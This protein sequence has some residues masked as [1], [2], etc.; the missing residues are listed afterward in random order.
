MKIE[1]VVEYN[2][3]GFLVHAGNLQGAYVRGRTLEEALEKFQEE[4]ESYYGWLGKVINFEAPEIRVVQTKESEL[5]IH[6]GDTDILFDSEKEPLEMEK[7]LELKRL[8]LKSALDFQLLFDSIPDKTST[9]LPERKTFYG[10]VPRTALEMYVH[11]K[12]VNAYYFGEIGIEAPNEPDIITSRFE[13]FKRLEATPDFLINKVYEGSFGEPWS[14]KKVLRRFVWHDR[15]H[16]K[17]M[18]RM[19]V[20]LFGKD[21]ILNPFRF[22]T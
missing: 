14:L 5:D 3:L 10:N 21:E 4:M 15:I 8:A 20:R 17:A 18:F 1:A 19:A 22:K 16:A 13:G 11:V 7:Y 2:N 6:D 9:D 12:N